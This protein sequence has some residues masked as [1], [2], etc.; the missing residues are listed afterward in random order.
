MPDYGHGRAFVLEVARNLDDLD[1]ATTYALEMAKS[2]SWEVERYGF[3]QRDARAVAE[4]IRALRELPD[5]GEKD[6]AS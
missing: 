3:S 2:L 5:S 1:L 4:R 6:T